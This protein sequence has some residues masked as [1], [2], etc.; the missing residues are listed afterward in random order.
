M[1]VALVVLKL[2]DALAACVVLAALALLEF[3]FAVDEPVVYLYSE[4]T[5]LHCVAVEQDVFAVSELGDLAE[6][7]FYLAELY[8]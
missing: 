4:L 1:L 7:H 8:D 5:N 2:Q 6:L 3:C